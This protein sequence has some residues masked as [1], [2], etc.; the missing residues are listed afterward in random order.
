M[1][2]HPDSD[3]HH[4]NMIELTQGVSV[5]DCDH[6]LDCLY[7]SCC[8]KKGGLETPEGV[9]RP[10]FRLPR[11]SELKKV[12]IKFR[13]R[14]GN[15][16]VV[17]YNKRK[18][19]LDLPKLAVFDETEDMLRNL[20]AYE[21]TSKAGGEFCGYAIMMDSLIDTPEDLAILYRSG[22]LEN[23]L[24]SEERLVTMW[25]EMCINITEGSSK[26]WEEITKN[27][28]VHYKSHWRVIYVEFCAKFFS[29]PWLWLS[30][31]AAVVL[32]IMS[33][34]QTVYSVLAYYQS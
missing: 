28:L 4:E 1:T 25:N 27:I 33:A 34:L 17:K 29:K 8:Q 11:A 22:V 20:V 21:L 23:H 30:T 6:L 7:I 31:L 18:L 5:L 19:R 13:A 9:Y 12:G 14:K 32:L 3:S 10:Q 15:I 26:R 24:G 2:S 16:S